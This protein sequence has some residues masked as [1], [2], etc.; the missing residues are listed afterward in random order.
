[1]AFD[2]LGVFT[3][4]DITNL[5]SYLQSQLDSIDAQ[6][7][8]TVLE[9]AKLQKMLTKLM[10]LADSRG[11]KFKTFGAMLVRQTNSQVNDADVARL[12][13]KIKEPYYPNIKFRDDIEHRIRKTIDR[14]EQAQERIHLLRISKSEFRS[15]FEIVNSKFDLYHSQLTVEQEVR[16]VV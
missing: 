10:T 13:Q 8:H 5:Q 7:N 3:K 4:Q 9:S 12:V 11:I 2:F 6:I 14:I 15:N 16:N 1:M